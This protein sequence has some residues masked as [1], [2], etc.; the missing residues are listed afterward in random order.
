[1]VLTRLLLTLLVVALSVYATD[2]LLHPGTPSGPFTPISWLLH[3]TQ[4]AA[5]AMCLWRAQVH[6]PERAAWRAVAAGIVCFAF[7]DIYWNMAL[8]PLADP[9]FP[10]AADVG[11]LGFPVSVYVGALLLLRCRFNPIPGSLWLDAIVAGIAV[12]AI[13]AALLPDPVLDFSG[14]DPL[15]LAVNLAYPLSDLVLIA[16]AA[17]GVVLSGLRPGR[18]WTLLLLGVTVFAVAD[19]TFLVQVVAGAYV[20][21]TILDAGWVAGMVLIALAAWQPPVIR[22][23]YRTTGWTSV[24][25]PAGAGLAC[26]SLQVLGD[27]VRVGPL[28][29]GLATLCLTLVIVRLLLTFRENL[30]LLSVLRAQAST[31]A[32]TGLGN[33]RALIDDLTRAFETRA[34]G[35]EFGLGI[36]DLDGFKAYN[37]RLGH[38]AGDHMLARLGTRL[39]ATV[40]GAGVAYRLGGDEFCVLSRPASGSATALAAAAAAIDEAGRPDGVS[41]SHGVVVLPREAQDVA[42]ALRIADSRMYADKTGGM[43]GE[44]AASGCVGVL[45]LQPEASSSPAPSPAALRRG[46]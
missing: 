22:R 37:D 42:M 8:S 9:P 12:A 20:E 1:M 19:T 6:P 2:T 7:G 33:R 46:V 21:N 18:T 10:S 17:A 25:V 45:E 26:L 36:Y 38:W 23:E 31:D 27:F 44:G 39:V 16:L 40:E 34:A 32:L 11:Y 29:T 5:A 24:A 43:G 3:A 41:C 30:S 14:A 13:V 15:V 4:F 28:S 35:E